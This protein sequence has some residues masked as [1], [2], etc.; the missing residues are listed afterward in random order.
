MLPRILHCLPL[1]LLGCGGQTT[2][3]PAPA[4]RRA[5]CPLAPGT[6]ATYAYGLEGIAIFPPDPSGSTRPL[7][8]LEGDWHTDACLGLAFDTSANLYALCYQA[9]ESEP[10]GQVNVFAPNAEGDARPVRVLS[11]PRT[12]IDGYFLGIA[13]DSHD[14]VYLVRDGGC[15][16]DLACDDEVLV[17]PPG[18]DGDTPPVRA[19]RGTHTGFSYSA[20]IAVD[21]SDRLYVGNA[22][23][24]PILVFS[25]DADG[26]ASPIRRI[27][28]FDDI[29]DVTGLAVDHDGAVYVT[30]AT[31]NAVL[32]Y[33]P[34]ASEG[35][36]PER[37][38]AGPATGLV[39]PMSVAVDRAKRLYVAD[40]DGAGTLR[41]FAPDAS[42]NVAADIALSPLG[43]QGVALACEN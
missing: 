36:A 11:G 27:G 28:T 33:A 24:G 9:V 41:L 34:A 13:V 32:V 25:P 16:D 4:G 12:G 18:A 5:A 20:A 21:E 15:N 43:G 38:I 29:G 37:V 23:G 10:P 31:T 30:D 1:L 14:Y 39:E 40:D 2:T 7:T 35:D 22:E 42:G 19:I 8:T 6:I 3:E 26:D 17:F